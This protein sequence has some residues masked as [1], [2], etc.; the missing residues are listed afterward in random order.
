MAEITVI[1]ALKL[2]PEHRD[3]ALSEVGEALQRTANDDG[4][5]SLRLHHDPADDD[6]IVLIEEW[7]SQELFEQH[8]ALPHMTRLAER[9]PTL[10]AGPPDVQVLYPAPV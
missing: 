4:C 3:E 8:M 6:R 5:R 2:S 9:G 1:V 7:Q 10:F